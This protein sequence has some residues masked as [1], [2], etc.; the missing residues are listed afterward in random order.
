M[1]FGVVPALSVALLLIMAIIQV[2]A[3]RSVRD[4]TQQIT[5]VGVRDA[6]RLA[7]IAA[8]F[9]RADADLSRLLN[10]EAAKPGR[11]DIA[12]S[13]K[14]ILARLAGVRSDLQAFRSTEI[15]RANAARID[16]ALND[17]D[18]YSGAVE[19]V[20]SM[21]G[22]NFASAVA[23][24]E[25]FQRYAQK[26][27]AN[28]TEIARSGIAESN[29]HAAS[30]QREVV[31]T[32]IIFSLLALIAVPLIAIATLLVGIATVRSIRA[33]AD[34][35]ADLANAQ[36]DID[37]GKLAR[38][39]ELGAVV[40]ALETFRIQ[41]LE[42]RRVREMEAESH[43]LQLA[44]SAAESANKAKSDFL[45]NMSHEL[46]TPLNAILG[47]AQLL[48]RDPALSARQTNAAKTID[49]S[50]SHLLTL[51]NDILDLSKIEAGKVDICPATVDLRALVSGIADIVRIRA[52]EKA[53]AFTC[54]CSP[55]LPPRLLVDGK[56]LRQVLINLLGN[57]VKFTD[58]GT[59]DLVVAL[60]SQSQDRARIRFEVR[61]TGVGLSPEELGLI[62]QPF[63]QV[64]DL[65]KRSGG[66]GLGLSISRQ[67]VELMGGRIEVTSE[68]GTGSTF[69][70]ELALPI[71][72]VVPAEVRACAPVTGYSGKRRKI[73]VVDDLARNRE[74]LAE[75]L[76]QLEFDVVH[77][78][79]GKEGFNKTRAERPDLVLMDVRMP[80]MN[81]L[82]AIERLRAC[83]E[84]CAT[85]VIMLS[86]GATSDEEERCLAAGANGFLSKP[87]T[88]S[89]LLSALGEQLPIEWIHAGETHANLPADDDRLTV[90]PPDEIEQ[91]HC[92]AKAGNMRA[93]RAHAEALAARDASC[94]AFAAKLRQL[95]AGY[96]SQ[97]IL[98]L[99]EQHMPVRE[100]LDR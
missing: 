84:I 94:S 28:I 56:R 76:G 22:V 10:K 61:D 50:G 63:E 48:K 33:I 86:A 41:A 80:V 8:R 9:E 42:A 46:R 98:N 11:A 35:T 85:P 26:V 81:G 79:N 23:M 73:L 53:L 30:V 65:Q 78:E 21:L 49:E 36:Y 83:P 32:T 75:M 95:A 55:D 54:K 13:S 4:S 37:V 27:T 12:A 69:C 82:E 66:T 71:D 100:G 72:T 14:A 47:Y 19:V 7:D 16:E 18:Q 64:G 44:K 15:G 77:A 5:T 1:K 17:L 20:T 59:V 40:M 99:V 68:P 96:Q 43:R 74:V 3:L 89:A 31:M 29:R 88:E 58:R 92:L 87:I 51:I 34:A 67:L 57:A 39:D 24:L 62:F 45:A 2:T 6:A 60:Q 38:K 52:D 70:F 90:L 25:P 97:A 91:L 93:I